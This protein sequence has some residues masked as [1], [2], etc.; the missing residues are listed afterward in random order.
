M[1][2]APRS[3]LDVSFSHGTLAVSSVRP[4][5]SLVYSRYLDFQKVE[6]QNRELTIQNALCR[7]PRRPCD[8]YQNSSLSTACHE[9]CR[10]AP[11]GIGV[12]AR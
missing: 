6:E 7:R 11:H 12:E 1:E 5:A 9:Y 10:R 2:S 3:I 8:T 4:D